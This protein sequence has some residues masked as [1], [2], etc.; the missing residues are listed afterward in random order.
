MNFFFLGLKTS[1]QPF[2]G[3]LDCFPKTVTNIEDT[4]SFNKSNKNKDSQPDESIPCMQIDEELA[5]TSS[6]YSDISSPSPKEIRHSSSAVD[7]AEMENDEIANN[8]CLYSD[9]SSP[10]PKEIRHSSSAVAE[11]EME[12]EEIANNSCLYSDISSPS[13]KEIRH[14]SS[15]LAVPEIMTGLGTISSEDVIDLFQE[16]PYADTYIEA[17]YSSDVQSSTTT[18]NQNHPPSAMY[19]VEK[20]C[21]ITSH[22]GENYQSPG[23]RAKGSPTADDGLARQYSRKKFRTALEVIPVDYNE[24]GRRTPEVKDKDQVQLAKSKVLLCSC[25]FTS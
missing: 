11:A 20:G 3:K 9:I 6:L 18:S 13:P 19:S 10:S 15:A 21:R 7:V 17:D 16:F 4:N 5:N 1:L 24:R 14:H 22:T 25:C 23:P 2:L 12:N 8:S